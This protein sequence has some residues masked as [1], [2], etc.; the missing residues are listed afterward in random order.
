MISKQKKEEL[1]NELI[2]RLEKANGLYLVDFMHMTVEDS[3]RL[4]RSLKEKDVEFRVAK[5]TLIK[6]AFQT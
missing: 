4:R 5:N 2:E 1:V 3:I 6:R